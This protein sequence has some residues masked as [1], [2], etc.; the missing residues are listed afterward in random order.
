L[1]LGLFL[2]LTEIQTTVDIWT[3]KTEQRR[4][5]QR[6]DS[7]MFLLHSEQRYSSNVSSSIPSSKRTEE[8]QWWELYDASSKRHYYYNAKNHRTVW[9]RPASADIIPLAKLQ[10]VTNNCIID[11]AVVLVSIKRVEKHVLDINHHRLSL[12][13]R[14]ICILSSV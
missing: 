8:N 9:Q 13:R 2:C 4:R 10:V 11:S 5:A 6:I 1:T 14:K 12:S 3:I 7:P